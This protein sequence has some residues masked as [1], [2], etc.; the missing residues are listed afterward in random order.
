MVYTCTDCGTTK[1]EAVAKD[2][3]HTFGGYSVYSNTQHSKACACGAIEYEDHAWN[4]GIVTT[5]ATHL[6]DGVKTYTCAGCGMTNTEAIAKL[7]D[8]TYGDFVKKDDKQHVKVC[9]CGEEVVVDHAWGEAVTII[10]ATHTTE[11]CATYTC[12]DCGATKIE[13]IAKLA[14]HTYGAWENKD[15]SQHAKYCACGEAVLADHAW[16]EGV[17]T[18]NPTEVADGIKTFTCADCGATRTEKVEKLPAN[19][20]EAGGCSGSVSLGAGAFIVL[21]LGAAA[22]LPKKRRSH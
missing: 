1:T 16:N 21:C 10:A 5:A 17:V 4:S 20:V 7:T 19:D 22:V 6:A 12:T 13:T 8:H 18:S 15:E 3:V 14:D 9:D 2:T 11:G